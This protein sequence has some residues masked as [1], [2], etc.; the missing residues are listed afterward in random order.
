MPNAC[1]TRHAC[2]TLHDKH[3]GHSLVAIIPIRALRRRWRRFESYRGHT[4]GH[5]GSISSCPGQRPHA[6]SLELSQAAPPAPPPY[7]TW[8]MSAGQRGESSGRFAPYSLAVRSGRPVRPV[9]CPR[10][11]ERSKYR[12]SPTR[13]S[14]R[15][16]KIRTRLLTRISRQL[17]G[18]PGSDVLAV[19]ASAAL[20]DAAMSAGGLP[21]WFSTGQRPSCHPSVGQHEAGRANSTCARG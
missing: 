14:F 13:S 10:I 18:T 6:V 15:S 21:Q 11:P 1:P 19:A 3:A 5:I 17:L 4:N 16:L 9:C 2:L 20:P 8:S 7:R 12:P